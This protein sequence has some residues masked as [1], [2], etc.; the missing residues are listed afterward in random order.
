MGASMAGHLL[1][2]GHTLKVY[3][4][5]RS[6][7]DNLIKQGAV[8]CDTPAEASADVGVVITMLGFPDDVRATYLENGGIL[9]NAK[10][11]TL[12]IDMTTSQPQLAIEVAEAAASRGC[13]ALDAPVSGGDVGARE[14]RLS[15]MVGGEQSAFE[16]ALPLF[17][18][19]GT[20]IVRQGG[21]GAGQH[22]K[23]ANQILVA[24][25]MVGMCEA[26]QYANKAGLDLSTMLT[27]V[28]RGAAGS[29]ALTNLAPRVVAADYSPGFFVKHFVKD[30]RIALESA[31][32]MQLELPGLA[33]AQT[34]YARLQEMG[35]GDAGT[36]ALMKLYGL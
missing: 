3:N 20:N 11:V 17:E 5:T 1:E 31:H 33:L 15:I 29:W 8:W 24:A 7:A 34:L 2:A 9:T 13:V 21:A 10:P 36:Q 27:S 25:G 4:R 14:A 6:K 16:R 22:C 28:S 12:L 30:L 19:M 23:M 32:S 18:C 26:L 35:E